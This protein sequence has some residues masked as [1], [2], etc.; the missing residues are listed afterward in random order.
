MY[1]VFLAC[2]VPVFCLSFATLIG[3]L[4][5]VPFDLWHYVFTLMYL[6]SSLNPQGPVVQTLD[7]SIHRI[8]HYP[9]D[10]YLGNQLRYL[11]DRDLSSG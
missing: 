2:Y 1:V 10:K 8:N 9:A 11:L 5:A 4:T 6:N 7:S 3:G